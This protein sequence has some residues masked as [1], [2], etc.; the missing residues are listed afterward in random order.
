MQT[1]LQ[2]FQI[3]R[4][5]NFLASNPYKGVFQVVFYFLSHHQF[6]DEA[7]LEF[8]GIV[9]GWVELLYVPSKFLVLGFINDQTV[10]ENV[11]VLN[12]L[13]VHN[14]ANRV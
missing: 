5:L 6:D 3:Y 11:F 4:S 7:K 12:Y 1:T 10:D 8:V 13:Q 2:S 14:S 9:L